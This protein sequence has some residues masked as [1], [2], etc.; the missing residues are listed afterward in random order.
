MYYLTPMLLSILSC[1]VTPCV[2]GGRLIL[3]VC[4]DVAQ[5]EAWICDVGCWHLFAYHNTLSRTAVDRV[6]VVV[7]PGD[8]IIHDRPGGLNSSLEVFAI[9]LEMLLYGKILANPSSVVRETRIT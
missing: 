4:A 7:P 6:M 5:V 9:L 2:V 8:T 3:C 1:L